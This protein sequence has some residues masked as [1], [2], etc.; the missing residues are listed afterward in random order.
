MVVDN[1]FGNVIAHY[2][3]RLVAQVLNMIAGTAVVAIEP[4]MVVGPF[5]IVQY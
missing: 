2:L 3:Q 1:C 5:A 4:A